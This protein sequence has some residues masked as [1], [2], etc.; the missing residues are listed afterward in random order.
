MTI[1]KITTLDQ[2]GLGASRR[3]GWLLVGGVSVITAAGVL[4]TPPSTPA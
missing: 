2:T 3:I 4:R 1:N